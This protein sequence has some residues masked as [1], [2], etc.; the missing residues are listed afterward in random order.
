M[1]HTGKRGGARF[2]LD[3]GCLDAAFS[4]LKY[5]LRRR[6][7]KVAEMHWHDFTPKCC[8]G[9]R[10]SGAREIISQKCSHPFGH[11]ARG[12]LL[13]A[14]LLACGSMRPSQP[15][16]RFSSQWP[17]TEQTLTAHSCGGSSGIARHK[18]QNSPNSR[19][20]FRPLRIRRTL[21]TIYSSESDFFVNG[22]T[23]EN[24]IL[25]I[26]NIQ[27]VNNGK[28]NTLALPNHG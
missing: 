25:T 14:G 18:W 16:Q 2:K 20:S 13:K 7:Q 12:R 5:Y 22:L 6:A 17:K 10:Q 19:L 23:L 11:P 24:K 4:R 27:R 9:K 15:S 21:N 26:K 3:L 28:L 1:P 8:C